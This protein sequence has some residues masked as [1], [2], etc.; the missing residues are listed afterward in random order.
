MR[1]IPAYAR[2]YS[3]YRELD[4]R[5]SGE[6]LESR[7]RTAEADERECDGVVKQELR[8]MN[9][10]RVLY[11]LQHTVDKAHHKTSAYS[12][13]V[14]EHEYGEKRR[15]RHRSSEGH[16]EQLDIGQREGKRDTYRGGRYRARVYTAPAAGVAENTD[17][18]KHDDEHAHADVKGG[19][20]YGRGVG[21][22]ISVILYVRTVKSADKYC[23][24]YDGSEKEQSAYDGGGLERPRI[25]SA[26]H[27]E[28][29]RGRKYYAAYDNDRH[30]YVRRQHVALSG[31]AVRVVRKGPGEHGY[32]NGYGI[33][34]DADCGHFKKPCERAA[35][36]RIY[37][38]ACHHESD[39]YG[40]AYPGDDELEHVE[41]GGNFRR[42]FLGERHAF[43]GRES[44]H[45]IEEKRGRRYFCVRRDGFTL[46]RGYDRAR[47]YERDGYSEQYPEH[48]R[49]ERLGKRCG[50]ACARQSYDSA[51]RQYGCHTV[52]SPSGKTKSRFPQRKAARSHCVK[53][54][55]SLLSLRGY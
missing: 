54:L 45:G 52:F 27:C 3:A 33:H 44:D 37:D 7:K 36:Y 38:R 28:Q 13:D 39:A 15:E 17:K 6:R 25:F 8:W 41:S 10:V 46:C 2:K 31:I 4:L 21:V 19:V 20:V 35:L 11:S 23:R 24:D 55:R 34:D 48:Y 43:Y 18:D 32:R 50:A 47:D 30:E 51:F 12:V 16:V 14:G 1:D 40:D 9:D 29:Y 53:N 5:I 49:L 22:V 26:K 42:A